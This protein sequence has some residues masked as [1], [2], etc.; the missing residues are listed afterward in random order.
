MKRI[1]IC[2]QYAGDIETNVKNARRY[3]QFVA[4]CGFNPI[5]SHLLYPQFLDDNSPQ[6]RQLGLELGLDL[7]RVCDELWCFGERISNGMKD[8]IAKANEWG[9]VVRYSE[10][11]MAI[12]D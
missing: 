10:D 5:A 1:Y 6:E 7:L 4:E 9:I 8:E 12:I 2:S 11:K 3:C